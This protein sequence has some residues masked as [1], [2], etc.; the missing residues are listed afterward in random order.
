MTVPC[1]CTIP[2]AEDGRLPL[3]LDVMRRM[4]AAVGDTTAL[5]GLICGP[6]TL[7]SHLRGNN[8]FMDMFDNDEYVTELL[9]FCN[10]VACKMA[11]YYIDA[12]MD[13][14]AVV[15]PLISQIS[16]DHF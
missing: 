7:A 9:A 6:F 4:K 15:D 14:I 11:D 16:S 13:V 1:E 8:I 10:K 3:V 12:G 2:T 5:Y